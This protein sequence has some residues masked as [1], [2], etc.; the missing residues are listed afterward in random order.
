MHTIKHNSKPSWNR[1]MHNIITYAK[2]T[3]SVCHQSPGY[4]KKQ[5]LSQDSTCNNTYHKSYICIQRVYG[6]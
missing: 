4:Y 2:I 5:S 3:E 6:C 1:L